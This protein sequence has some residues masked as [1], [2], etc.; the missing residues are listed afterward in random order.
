MKTSRLFFSGLACLSSLLCCGVPA[1][2]AAAQPKAEIRTPPVIDLPAARKAGT[3]LVNELLSMRPTENTSTK[4]VLRITANRQTQQVP[5]TF[6]VT[7][8]PSSW[9]S[10]YDASLKSGDRKGMR[11][12]IEQA[13][14]AA[15]KY[16]VIEEGKPESNPTGNETM[17]PFAGSDFW[18]ADL[19][20]E[21]LHWPEQ[22][23]TGTEMRRG[24][25]CRV[26]ESINPNP[27]PGSYRR[28]VS[29]ID[30]D[31]GAIIHADAYDHRN[32]L[33]KQFAPKEVEKIKGQWQLTEMEMRNRQ[34][35]SRTRIEF[36]LKKP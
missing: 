17:I 14:L 9:T 28:V 27:A 31:S 33:L 5:F 2:P 20:L 11:L 29:W 12:V 35:G 25:S 24:Q 36:D 8:G 10:T 19:G 26:L 34:T 3:E 21:F 16:G 23:V 22:R 30:I 15:N 32:T 18:V 13:P 1:Q 4:G 7:N 6:S